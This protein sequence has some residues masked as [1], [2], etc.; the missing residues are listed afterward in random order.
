[1]DRP[2]YLLED[3]ITEVAGNDYQPENKV[4]NTTYISELI[5]DFKSGV[6]RDRESHETH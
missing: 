6:N 4:A 1:M 5:S 2:V 3:L